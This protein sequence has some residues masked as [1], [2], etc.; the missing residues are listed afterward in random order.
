MRDLSFS[1]DTDIIIL[2]N[3]HSC[4]PQTRNQSI[5]SI[6][7]PWKEARYINTKKATEGE[8]Q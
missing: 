8:K 1:N 2:F 3:S 7:I 6:L 4:S 5:N